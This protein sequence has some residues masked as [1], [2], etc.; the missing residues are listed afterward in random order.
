MRAGGSS[1]APNGSGG[2]PSTKWVPGVWAASDANAPARTMVLPS[3]E[4]RSRVSASTAA[5]GVQVGRSSGCTGRLAHDGLVNTSVSTCPTNS[6][7]TSPLPPTSPC[8]HHADPVAFA[9]TVSSVPS[10][11][12]SS[13]V[14]VGSQ[15]PQRAGVRAV[16]E[17]AQVGDP[18]CAGGWS[19]HAGERA[20]QAI[21]DRRE[22]AGR[23]R[24]WIVTR[25]REE[26]EEQC[27]R[28]VSER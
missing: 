19:P 18:G 20:A 28:T 1:D 23:R 2:P 7:D 11:S 26:Q 6:A 9:C 3:A 21:G 12:A 27:A 10:W 17:H 25:L 22:L 15:A 4:T 8:T 16:R 14:D 5:Y 13:P 24:P